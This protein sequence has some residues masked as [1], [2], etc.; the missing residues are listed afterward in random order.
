MSELTDARMISLFREWAERKR[1]YAALVRL[2]NETDAE[3]QAQLADDVEDTIGSIPASGASALAVKIYLYLHFDDSDW[4]EDLAAL[5]GSDLVE[6][7]RYAD[8]RLKRSIL[9]DV[10]RFVPELAPLAADYI[11]GVPPAS[12]AE[13]RLV[14]VL[15]RYAPEYVARV[16]AGDAATEPEVIGFGEHEPRP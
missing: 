15:E 13:R 3:K 1:A 10:V 5:S 14:E 16:R 9:K 11:A 12:P 6:S 8:A 2:D 7:E 4:R